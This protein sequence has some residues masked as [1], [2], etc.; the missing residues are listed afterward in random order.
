MLCLALW[1]VAALALSPELLD[2]NNRANELRAEGRYQEA[3]PFA[4]KALRLGEEEFGPDDLTEAKAV[5]KLQHPVRA[6]R[7]SGFLDGTHEVGS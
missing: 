4:E 1:P 6:R 2:A 3:I 7:L 5:R